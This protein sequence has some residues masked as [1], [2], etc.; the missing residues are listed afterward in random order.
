MLTLNAWLVPGFFPWLAAV[1]WFVPIILLRALFTRAHRR[2]VRLVKTGEFAAAISAFQTCYEQM[3]RHLWIDRFRWLLLGTSSRWS[4]RELA[5]CNCAFCYG[6]MGDGSKMSAFYSQ[7]LSEFP[8][9]VLATTAIRMMKAVSS[10]QER[11]NVRM[12]AVVRPPTAP[13]PH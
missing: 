4:F 2:G 5:L 3:S 12:P 9:S 6:Q 10:D 7:A 11:N 1:A 13:E 8:K